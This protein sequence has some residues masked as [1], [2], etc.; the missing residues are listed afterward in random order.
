MSNGFDE[1]INEAQQLAENDQIDD[2]IEM[3]RA[4]LEEDP[5]NEDVRREVID[6]TLSKSDFQQ[7]IVE[8][9]DWAEA[10][11]AAGAIDDAIRIYQEILG[12]DTLL[13][14]K[15]FMMDQGVAEETIAQVQETIQAASGAIFFNLGYLYLEKGALDESISCLQK[16]LEF[17]PSDSKTH[18]LLGQVYMQKGLDKEAIGEFQEVV[19]LAPDE[20]AYAYEML[21]EIFIRTGKPP[22]STIVWFRNAGDLYIRHEQYEEAIRAYERIL[23]FE[24]ENKDILLKLGEVYARQGNLEQAS[25]I[26]EQLAEILTKEGMLDKV[27]ALYQKIIEWDPENMEARD[28]IIDIYRKILEVD[29][30][31][32][33]ARSK[34]IGN[35]LRK[36]AAEDAIPEFI[37]L[38][39]TYLDKG[40]R[41]EA[42]LVCKKLLDL[43][44]KNARAHEII[45]DIKFDQGKKEESL[46]EY[47]AA[48]NLY[49]K[50]GEEEEA[51]R[52]NKKLVEK[53][54]GTREV[55]IQMAQSYAER[56]DYDQALLQYKKILDEEPTNID[57][58]SKMLEIFEVKEDM[59]NVIAFAQRIMDLDPTRTDMQEKIIRIYEQQGETDKILEIYKN[60]LGQDPSRNDI[61]QK[62]ID[63]YEEKGER[64]KVIKLY[65]KILEEEPDRIEIRQKI[66]EHFASQGRIKDVLRESS[67]L[68]DVFL[69]KE[70]ME[71]A[72]G[73]YK[74]IL[75][76]VP[77]DV[78][79]RD[80]LCRI[81]EEKGDVEKVQEELLI[82]ANIGLREGDLESS[83]NRYKRILEYTPND[84][85]LKTKIAKIAADLGQTEEAVAH[86]RDI[87]DIYT[88][89]KM[90]EPALN[91]IYNILEV[92]ED[93]IEYRQKL[94]EILK[95]QLETE[96]MI[97]QY[98]L[99]IRQLGR[100]G[101]SDQA[102]TFARDAISLQPMDLDFRKEIIDLFL[103]ED[104]I[105]NA[106]SFSDE[107]IDLYLNRSEYDEVIN[108]YDRLSSVYRQKNEMSTYYEFRKNI[109]QI[110]ERQ[111]N[112]QGAIDEYMSIL[113]S[114]LIDSRVDEAERL[115]P[116]VINLY[117]KE[118][119]PG[120]AVERFQNMVSKMER[121]SR[122]EEAVSILEH[123]VEIQEKVEKFEEALNI[124]D[125]KIELYRELGKSE[126]VIETHRRK[127]EIFMRQKMVDRGIDEMFNIIDY[128]LKNEDTE[129]AMEQFREVEQFEPDD[130]D[131]LFRMAEKLF[132]YEYFDQAKEMYERV[133]EQNSENY[134]A[135]ARVAIIFSKKGKLQ[136]AVSYTRKIF[137]KGLVA[138]VI[139]EYKKSYQDSENEA[140]MHI[141]LGLF[142]QKMGFIEEAILEFQ[143]AAQDP[144]KLLEA[145]NLM[146]ICFKEEGFIDLAVRQFERALEQPGYPEEDYLS[147]RYNLGETLLEN[148]QLE[149][150]LSAF[151]ECYMVDINYRDIAEKINFLNEKLSKTT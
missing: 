112:F 116:L 38:S 98:K 64:G 48:V 101:D 135:M 97:K 35:I 22:Q 87:A 65:Q 94:I 17:N 16:S 9:F 128:H 31:N 76:F 66:I 118:D 130:P 33:T 18:T 20:A 27:V 28:K 81:Y 89:K 108:I 79:T 91:T 119:R 10:C 71:K 63:I 139:D 151:Y 99:L 102:I 75:A 34:L 133:L 13:Q 113:E 15:V 147:I 50:Q 84:I 53:F 4:A 39:E 7:A 148:S 90:I 36:G 30:S 3:Y 110:Y 5:T 40:M 52:V 23:S 12:L 95:N 43:D 8:Y 1:Y 145:Y 134:D 142:Y 2:A 44:A 92:D 77:D 14:K 100:M 122:L 49:R 80:H 120:E 56:G 58:L 21:G 115:F 85:N 42:F 117:F 73:L 26:Y 41:K 109:A 67:A 32:L 143:K 105:E 149:E 136:D 82:L 114:V 46:K 57:I 124:L 37:A 45:A 19:R 111:A 146:A 140:Q 107:L 126:K 103:E 132:E 78:T 86:Y 29:P 125:Q 59:E 51:S 6:L 74:N 129:S 141:D 72:E 123:M 11:Q 54:P 150:A 144:K 137:S 25:Q 69:E 106:R 104:D 83:L 47:M 61:R 93:N 70:E 96:E 88:D 62:M 60:I 138:E 24:S 131:V 121:F 127:I 55:T 68:A